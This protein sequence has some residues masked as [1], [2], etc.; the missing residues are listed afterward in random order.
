MPSASRG[1]DD[2]FHS[3]QFGKIFRIDRFD[4]SCLANCFD[5]FIA[6]NKPVADSS[7]GPKGNVGPNVQQVFKR[8]EILLLGFDGRAESG[9]SWRGSTLSQPIFT[10]GN[11]AS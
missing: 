8:S 9:L 10:P 5:Q 4:S 2:R 3:Q 7:D 11:N 1:N 6:R